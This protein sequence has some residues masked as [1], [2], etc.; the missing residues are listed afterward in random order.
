MLVWEENRFVTNG[1]QPLE[2]AAFARAQRS[3]SS[4]A[5]FN[6]SRYPVHN[7][8]HADPVLVQDAVDMV[9]RDR[10]HPSIIIWSLCNELGCLRLDASGGTVAMEF[11]LALYAVDTSRPITGNTVQPEPFLQGALVD[12]FALAMDV[13][14]F[15]YDYGS[16]ERYHRTTPWKPT[17]GGESG[18]C[19]SDRDYYGPTNKTSGHLSM[20]TYGS[21]SSLSEASATGV[22]ACTAR[23][24]AAAASRP[25]IYG[26][27]LWTGY[28]YRGETMLGWPDVSSHFGSFDIAGFA[29]DRI[30]YYHAWWGDWRD[31]SGACGGGQG[32]GAVS[33]SLSPSRD[34]TAPVPEGTAIPVTVTT[35]AAFVELY[36][37][38]ILQG[39]GRR[40]M[41]Q[42]GYLNWTTTF[43]RGNLTAVALDHTGATLAVRTLLSA[44]APTALRL[45]IDSPYN[46]KR[47][48]SVI[49]ADGMDAALL[50]AEIIDADGVLV[51]NADAN[52][53]IA[54]VGPAHVKGVSNG[55]PAYHGPE[56]GTVTI[57]TF[58]GLARVII[59]SNALGATGEIRVTAT[60]SG[61][62]S[63]EVRL[64]ATTE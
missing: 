24:W 33:L 12:N 27:Y 49:A 16:Y 1:V 10:N 29:K 3:S 41:P 55:D 32:A 63:G 54:I 44:G 37:N 40:A 11:K 17:G 25:W 7:D 61:L 26:S 46:W 19:Q 39:S 18:S 35:C 14:S 43:T 6:S 56:V 47:N 42:F 2:S 62:V 23:S 64:V 15:S 21:P 8:S 45:T 13:Q 53:S 30:G 5:I 50:R 57:K 28:D 22:F 4:S 36:L 38:G 34:W 20:F 9:T 58:H 51:P 52:V 31:E 59:S 48:G 60:A